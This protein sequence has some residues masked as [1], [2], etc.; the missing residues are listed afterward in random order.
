MF[1]GLK[2][3]YDICVV[4]NT[5]TCGSKAIYDICVVG[6]T[7]LESILCNCRLKVF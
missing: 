2:A 6:N 5:C 4:G 3:I 7:C 1:F